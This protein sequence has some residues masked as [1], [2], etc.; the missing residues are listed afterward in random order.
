MA[1]FGGTWGLTWAPVAT[2]GTP[3]DPLRFT[4]SREGPVQ[5]ELIQD[6]ERARRMRPRP[7]LDHMAYW[8]E[9]IIAAGNRL[10]TDGFTPEVTDGRFAYLR[11]PTGLR[12]ELMDVAVKPGWDRWLDGAPLN[13]GG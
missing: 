8:V 10:V 4:C 7:P 13:L 12:I 5:I 9:D 11:S 3:S 2:Y 6:A 1:S